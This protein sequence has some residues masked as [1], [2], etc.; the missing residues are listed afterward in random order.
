M[1]AAEATIE[2][3]VRLKALGV[4]LA[5]DDFGKGLLVF[6]LRQALPRRLPEDRSLFCRRAA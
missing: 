4:R 3:V 5:I 2:T 6:R 1:D